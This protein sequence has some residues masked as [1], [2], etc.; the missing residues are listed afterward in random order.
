MI[1]LPSLTPS[2]TDLSDTKLLIKN[3][4]LQQVFLLLIKFCITYPNKKKKGK[5]EIFKLYM[6]K[7]IDQTS[8]MTH[9]A[10]HTA[11]SFLPS[12]FTCTA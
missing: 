6:M 9:Q 5:N 1:Y 4:N 10:N 3:T 11:L 7:G 2:N 8:I 12:V